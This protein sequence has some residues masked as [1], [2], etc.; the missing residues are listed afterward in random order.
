MQGT[1]PAPETGAGP[2]GL[3]LGLGALSGEPVL[4]PASVNQWREHD[5]GRLDYAETMRWVI[6]GVTFTALGF[7]TVLSY[8]F[9]IILGM[10][11]K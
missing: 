1:E 9:L 8:F 3:L 4:L 6:P 5:C 10:R 11:R 2:A 7:Q